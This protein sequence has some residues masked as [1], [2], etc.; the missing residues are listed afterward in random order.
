MTIYCIAAGMEEQKSGNLQE[1][2]NHYQM[3]CE[4][5]PTQGPLRACTPYFSLAMQMGRLE[6]A[7]TPFESRCQSGEDLVCF[8]LAKEYIK[9]T[10]YIKAHAHLEKLCRTHFRPPDKDDYGPCYHLG[11]SLLKTGALDRALEIFKYDCARD[12]ALAKPS[13]GQHASLLA[14]V[15]EEEKVSQEKITAMEPVEIVSLLFLL[16]P[17]AG[18]ILLAKGSQTEWRFMRLFFPVSA[19]VVWGAWEFIGVSPGDNRAD[20]AFIFPSI[21]LTFFLAWRAHQ[22]IKRDK[23]E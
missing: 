16:M 2:L 4:N 7:A 5:H 13:C 18:W 15:E 17:L 23:G 20:L 11:R 3:A 12:P 9:I 14:R 21:L 22:F 8:Y 10:A 1:A 19:L 6:E